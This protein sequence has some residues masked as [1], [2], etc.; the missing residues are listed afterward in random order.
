MDKVVHKTI[1]HCC[2]FQVFTADVANA[3]WNDARTACKSLSIA[4][5]VRGRLLTASKQPLHTSYTYKKENKIFLIYNKIQNGAVAKSYMM[6]GFLI[7]VEMRKY[8][9]IYEEAVSHI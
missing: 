1:T 9:T 8:L 6:N 4:R 5:S 2:S 7:Y 3:T